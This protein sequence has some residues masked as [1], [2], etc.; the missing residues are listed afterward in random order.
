MQQLMLRQACV[1]ELGL[2]ARQK[3]RKGKREEAEATEGSVG[4]ARPQGPAVYRIEKM[5]QDRRNLLPGN[6]HNS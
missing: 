2:D 5:M 1:F 3:E 4:M 6:D